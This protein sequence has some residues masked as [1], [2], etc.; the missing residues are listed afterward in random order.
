MLTVLYDLL[1]DSTLNDYTKR[2][3][4]QDFDKVLSLDL[5]HS[6]DE[7]DENLQKIIL[8]KIELRREA[9]EN[10]NYELADQI[11]NEL[12]DMGI[13]LIDSKDG[14]TYEKV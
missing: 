7:I 14:T 1:K 12:L 11:R 10:K 8:E 3:I 13:K 2:I 4:I 6:E 5:F 9:R